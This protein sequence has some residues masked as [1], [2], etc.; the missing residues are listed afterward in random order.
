MTLFPLPELERER[1]PFCDHVAGRITERG[2]QCAVVR[3]TDLTLAWVAPFRQQVGR[4]LVGPKR[5][6]PTLFDLTHQE[7]VGLIREVRSVA[8]AVTK[9][10]EPGGITVYQ[11]NGSASGQEIPHVHMHV[12][13]RYADDGGPWAPRGPVIP[14]DERMTTAE[15]V[16]QYL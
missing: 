1:C 14:F 13:P 11:N 3:A 5:H 16:K 4:I 15:R 2:M 8:L 9:A 7:L 12:V 10:F 6:A